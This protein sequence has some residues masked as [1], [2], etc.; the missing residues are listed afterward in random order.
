MPPAVSYPDYDS[1]VR[2][3]N[4]ADA[5]I[6]V[7]SGILAVALALNKPTVALFG[8][9]HSGIIADQ[10]SRYHTLSLTVLKSERADSCQR[11]CNFQPE[12]GYGKDG[13]CTRTP[14]SDCMMEIEPEAVVA[15][16]LEK[17]S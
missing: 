17:V 1:L 10:F 6:A 8:P 7:D 9:T 5:V 13:K 16:L 2:A 14:V 12:R 3:V 15:A 11:P 4:E